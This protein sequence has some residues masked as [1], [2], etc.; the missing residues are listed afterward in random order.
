MRKNITLV[1]KPELGRDNYEI[2]ER[3]GKG[4]PD[5]LSDTLAE[6]LSNAYS[7]YTLNNFGAVLHHNFDKVGMMGGKCEVEFGHG[8]MLEPIRVLLNGRASSK[9]GDIKINVKEILLNET[10]NFFAECFPML[11]FDSDVRILYE[12]SEGSSPGGV[13]GKESKRHRWFEPENLDDL[14]ELKKLN[15]NDTSMGCSFYG[16][17]IL[18]NIVYNLEKFLNSDEY[19][20]SHPWIGSDIKIMGFRDNNEVSITMCVPQLCTFVNNVEEYLSLIHISEPTRPY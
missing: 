15:C 19:K 11:N 14:G 20:I 5:T 1:L 16:Y 6:R 13:K 18:E 3:K 17:S 8:R 12:V 10:R 7:K 9:F 4:H 2:V